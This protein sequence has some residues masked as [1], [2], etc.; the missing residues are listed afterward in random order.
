MDLYYTSITHVKA[1][2]EGVERLNPHQARLAL[3]QLEA[4]L[5]Q[6]Y[7]EIRQLQS[8]INGHLAEIAALNQINNS[9]L[10]MIEKLRTEIRLLNEEIE[11]LKRQLK[12]LRD[13]D[14]SL[15]EEIAKRIGD[16]IVLDINK[17]I[18]NQF[19]ILN[20]QLLNQNNAVS[21]LQSIVQQLTVIINNARDQIIQKIDDRSNHVIREVSD[22]RQSLKEINDKRGNMTNTM[23]EL[24]K[25]QERNNQITL[26]VQNYLVGLR[27]EFDQKFQNILS[28]I[29]SSRTNYSDLLRNTQLTMLNTMQN[30]HSIIIGHLQGIRSCN[31]NRTLNAVTEPQIVPNNYVQFDALR[32]RLNYFWFHCEKYFIAIFFLIVAVFIIIL[33]CLFNYLRECTLNQ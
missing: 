27:I 9:R 26:Q 25:M 10:E 4:Y 20:Q 31:C 23:N 30:N 11:D 24:N 17:T 21:N 6:Q 16:R 12:Q 29:V 1:L 18:Q 14:N 13:R 32:P 33:G 28:E 22:L 2:I 8:V 7:N 19:N 15:V 3:Q 5:T